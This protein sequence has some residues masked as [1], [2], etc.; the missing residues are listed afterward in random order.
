MFANLCTINTLTEIVSFDIT[1]VSR[2]F[3]MRV[4]YPSGTNFSNNARLSF[5][6]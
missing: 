4:T 6:E 2:E 5:D 3:F 1:C